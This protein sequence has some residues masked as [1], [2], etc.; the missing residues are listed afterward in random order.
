[1][2]TPAL[3]IQLFGSLNLSWGNDPL[4]TPGSPTIRSLLAYVILNHNRPV[5]RDRLVGMF[6]PERSDVQARRALSNALWRIRQALGPAATRLVMEPDTITFIIEPQDELD[7]TAFESKAHCDPNQAIALYQ[8]EF[9]EACYDDWAIL[10]RERLNELYLGTLE[11]LV[12]IQ[13]QQGQYDQAI[14]YSLRLV[15]A[16]PLRETA[17]QD[18]MRLYCFVGRPQAAL[19][20]FAELHDLLAT[21]LDV[22]PMPTTVA[23]YEEIKATL[24]QGDASPLAPPLLLH[25][26]SRLPFVGRSTERVTLLGALQATAQ[27]HGGVVLVRGEAGVGK[28]RLIGEAVADAEWHTFQVGLCVAKPSTTLTAY[29]S[30]QIALAPLLT[31]LRVAQLSEL[32]EPLW[33]GAVAPVFPPLLQHLKFSPPPPLE[34]QEEQRRLWEGIIRLLDGLASI[35][36]VLLVL[37]DAHWMD[38]ATLAV[39]PH[40]ASGLSGARLLLVLSYRPTE[41]RERT[42]VWKTFESL[43]SI[44]PALRLEMRPFDRAETVT[45]VQRALGVAETEAQ[46]IAFAERIQG[47]TNG[48]AFLLIESLKSLVEQGHLSRSSTGDWAFPPNDLPLLSATSIQELVDGRLAHLPPMPQAVLELAAV[49]GEQVEFPVLSGMSMAEPSALLPALETLTLHGFLV[50]GETHYRFGHDYI[51]E[52]AY[53]R[54]APERRRQMHCNAG[55]V[56]EKLYPEQVESLA[57]HYDRGHIWKKAL[58]YH[59]QA[60]KRAVSLSAYPVALQHYDRAVAQ[61]DAASLPSGQYFDLLSE[62]ESV[63]DVLGRREEQAA[64]LEMMERLVSEDNVSHNLSEMYRRKARFL[65]QTNRYVEAKATVSLALTLA[66][67][68]KDEAG[69]A[70]ALAT[71]GIINAW[72]GRP[73]EAISNFREAIKLYQCRDPKG[74]A[75][76]RAAL[77]DALLSITAF[78][79]AEQELKFALSLSRSLKDRRGEAK[80]LMNLGVLA[81]ERSD[82]ESAI[83]C[84]QSALEISREIGYRYSE[85]LVLGNLSNQLY[86]Q[87]DVA[88]AIDTYNTIIPICRAIGERRVEA[89]VRINK[90]TIYFT[91]IGDVASA[92]A[93]VAFSLDYH[94][95]AGDYVGEGHCMCVRGQIAMHCGRLKEARADLEQGLT[96]LVAAGERWVAL[97]VYHHLTRLSLDE[98]RPDVAMYYVDEAQAICQE[99][100][101]TDW[102]TSMLALR[103]LVLLALDQPEAALAATTEAV[104]H[105]T[106]G[107]PEAHLIFFWHYRALTANRQNAQ[108]RVA[109]QEAYETLLQTLKGFSSE[110]RARSLEQIKEHRAIVTAW[111]S[112]QP[113]QATFCLPHVAAPIA[114]RPLREDEWINVTWTVSAPEDDEIAGKVARRQHQLLRLLREANEQSA[115]PTVE[116]LSTALD[117]AQRTLKRDLAALRAQG[118]DVRTR[119]RR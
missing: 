37:E 86:L 36:P 71:L 7:V 51:L 95:E 1:M 59:W 70:S 4:T 99:L 10:E 25:D 56:L 60:G 76:V 57:L 5:T 102:A 115:A 58:R 64:D 81:M 29:H 108:A 104:T 18:L 19:E 11:R 14:T 103:G 116:A 101:L 117:V 49:L 47:D 87:G 9:M 54:I 52:T 96:M 43:D 55:A 66:D 68:E 110:E 83:A 45:L 3:Q 100:D 33:L 27:G 80:A 67:L 94:R 77:G 61:V 15:A 20:Q 91:L 23:L 21:E 16:D 79:A 114:G 26:L 85:V 72:S 2:G 106:S 74:E 38:D 69:K 41:A 105:L 78:E 112:S 53:G 90:A 24:E 84:Y 42:S 34:P 65:G 109:I 63:L 13:K 6:W 31:P 39:L 107:I 113:H 118:N 17:H 32:V 93:D 40:L 30:L 35:A 98:G 62:R 48:N 82:A 88:Q 119:G 111:E 44:L 12:N 28:S 75:E 89:Q 50:E 97:Q 8:A 46:T 73:D 92:L 22:S